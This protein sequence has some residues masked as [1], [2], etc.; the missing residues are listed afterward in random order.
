VNALPVVVL[1]VVIL[2]A[3]AAAFANAL[4]ADFVFDDVPRIVERDVELDG[5]AV[6]LL[7]GERRPVVTATLALNHAVGGLEPR[8]YHAFNV[9]LHLAAALILFEVVRGAGTRV[10]GAGATPVAF[11][12]ALLWVVH[13]LQTESVTYVIQRAEV[14]AAL[15]ALVVL[16]AVLRAADSERPLAWGA[17][18]VIASIIGMGSKAT[19]VMAPP[20]AFLFDGLLVAPSFREAWRRRWG[21]HVALAAT[22]L[23]LI[24]TGV[25]T[26]LLGQGTRAGAAVGFGVASVTPLEYLATQ[27]GVIVHYLRLAAWPDALCIDPGWPVAR[28]LSAILAPA[29]AVGAAATLVLVA[30][31]RRHPLAFPGLVLLGWLLPTSSFVPIHDLAAEHRMYLPLA[32]PLVIAVATVRVGLRRLVPGAAAPLGVTLLVAATMALGTRTVV[33]N[34]NYASPLALWTATVEVAPHNRRARMNLG[35]AMLEA[36]RPDEA[37]SWLAEVVA[38]EPRDALARLNYG[39]ALVAAGRPDEGVAHLREAAGRLRQ[40]PDA[41]LSLAAA[42][43]EAGRPD[44]AVTTYRRVLEA[45]PAPSV[46]LALGNA[47]TEAG[48]HDEAAEAFTEAAALAADAGDSAL[49]ASALYNLGNV[50][51]RTG[52]MTRAAVAYRAALEAAPDHAGAALWL[53]RAEAGEGRP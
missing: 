36:G 25:V 24:P 22:W 47:L 52:N 28:G 9:V 37:A 27:P 33:R 43:R 3:G 8:G 13:P 19:M 40:R 45:A 12:A 20:L 44:E 51:Y 38:D 32:A 53:P 16:F 46:A 31:W 1:R 2:A 18:A 17:V 10:I 42:L 4:A 34:R 35:V 6:T 7:R 41:E 21:L 39:R 29:L 14:L 11:A 15:A 49:R 50:H 23:V 30:A 48:R 5:P 26:A